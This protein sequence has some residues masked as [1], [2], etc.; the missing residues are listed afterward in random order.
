M[1]SRPIRAGRP[2]LLGTMARTAVIAGTATAVSGAV[3]GHQRAKQAEKQQEQ[4]AEQ[5]AFD[6]QQQLAELQQQMASM[7]AVQATGAV[8]AAPAAGGNDF[9][10]RLNQLAEMKASGILTDA[11]FEA[12][13][14]RILGG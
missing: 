11:E 5:A 10:A 13:K 2:G 8:P 12:A 1:F 7:Q 6:S 3:S 9:M 4:A 14:A